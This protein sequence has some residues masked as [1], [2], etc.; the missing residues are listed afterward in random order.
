LSA[1][2]EW[3]AFAAYTWDGLMAEWGRTIEGL[4]DEYA[5][6][7]ARNQSLRADDMRYCDVLPFLRLTEEYKRVD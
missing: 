1:V 4:A 3:P 5:N 6:G 2:Q 7:V